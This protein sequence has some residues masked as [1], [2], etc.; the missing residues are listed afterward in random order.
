MLAP[1]SMESI[2]RI[3]VHSATLMDR[4]SPY[5][6]LLELARGKINQIRNQSADWITGGLHLPDDIRLGIQAMSHR[7]W[8]IACC[9]EKR[10]CQ[11][12]LTSFLQDTHHFS[13][14]M[15]G[16]YAGEAFKE[17]RKNGIQ[18]KSGLACSLENWISQ[19]K[20]VEIGREIFDDFR[21]PLPWYRIQEK[22]NTFNWGEFDRWLDLADE[23]SLS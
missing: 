13:Q 10:T 7:F 5:Q 23:A 17:Q 21:L 2:G 9:P 15:F 19:T 12:S 20:L 22:Q 4:S 3:Q 11:A 1:W 8:Q 14:K 18:R 16:F 6:F